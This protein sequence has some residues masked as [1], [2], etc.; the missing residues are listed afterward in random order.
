[1]VELYPWLKALH[2]AAMVTWLATLLLL[3][4]AAVSLMRSGADGRALEAVR[5]LYAA[6]GTPAMLATLALGIVMA[7]SAGWFSAGWL[8]AKLVLVLALAA[9]HGIASGSLRR[10]IESDVKAARRLVASSWL[11]FALLLA[12]AVLAVVKPWT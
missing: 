7:Q 10:L 1:M 12:I 3:P 4:A 2:V 8:Q 11:S 9:V 5:R 6:L